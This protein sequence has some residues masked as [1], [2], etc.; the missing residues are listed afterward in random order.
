MDTCRPEAKRP[1]LRKAAV[2]RLSGLSRGRG[3]GVVQTR[4][5]SLPLRSSPLIVPGDKEIHM[6]PSQKKNAISN[7]QT[8]VSRNSYLDRADSSR[9][10]K[11]RILKGGFSSSHI[12][13][14]ELDHKEG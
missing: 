1:G 10:T 8:E 7:F 4:G 13:M 14:C 5:P 2:G 11:V 3:A 6:L 12:R 9:Y